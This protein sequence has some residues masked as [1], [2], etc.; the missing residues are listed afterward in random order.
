LS[1][2]KSHKTIP[3]TKESVYIDR[4]I[5]LPALQEENTSLMYVNTCRMFIHIYDFTRSSS[6]TIAEFLGVSFDKIGFIKSSKEKQ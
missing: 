3:Y 2:I 4:D 5:P 6:M 1:W